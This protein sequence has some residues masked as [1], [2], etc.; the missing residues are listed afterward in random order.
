MALT[1]FQQTEPEV[2]PQ[3]EDCFYHI[4]EA[5]FV[6][7]GASLEFMI[8]QRLCWDGTC[9][10]FCKDSQVPKPIMPTRPLRSIK[11]AIKKCAS[12]DNYILANMSV[13]EVVFRILLGTGNRPMRL[14]EIV[15]QI[16]EEWQAVLAFKTVSPRTVQQMLD[17]ENEYRIRRTEA[18]AD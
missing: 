10:Q 12:Q 2:E 17:A 8:W 11:A 3:V 18:P 5:K 16:E 9:T 14:L 7:E 1:V 4:D 15:E 6:A 13:S